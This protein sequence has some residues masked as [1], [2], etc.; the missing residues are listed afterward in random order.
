MTSTQNAIFTRETVYSKCGVYENVVYN[1]NNLFAKIHQQKQNNFLN[2]NSD[3]MH[4]STSFNIG[5]DNEVYYIKMTAT[6]QRSFM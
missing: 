1:K 4:S 6:T 5:F 3:L 2:K